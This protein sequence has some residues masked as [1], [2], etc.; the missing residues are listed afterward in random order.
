[1]GENTNIEWAH[2]TCNFWI[3]CT[4][5]SPECERCYA[6]TLAKFHGWAK[7]GAKQPRHKTAPATVNNL[8]KWN[9][10]A[11]AAG[12][13]HR[14]FINSLS[15]TF[16]K[17]VPQSYRDAIFDYA[18]ETPFLD[19]LLLTKRPE[20]FEEMIPLSFWPGEN[21]WGGVTVGVRKS[22]ERIEYLRKSPFRIK[23]LS[24]EPLLEDLGTLNL[25]GIHWVIVGGESGAGARPMHPDWVRS[26]RDQ[27]IA[28]G[29]P[30]LFKQWGEW[31]PSEQYPGYPANM[32]T[33]KNRKS[34]GIDGT[35]P[36]PC[37]EPPPAGLKGLFR[38]GK[39]K[40]GRVL[41]SRTWDEFPS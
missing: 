13:R 21:I 1:M 40:A 23:F 31:C 6:E 2:H 33:L 10:A 14:V 20:N 26:I 7:W 12:E 19:Y 11:E 27:C 39:K 30:F 3:G 29:V 41:D 16:D 37:W 25:E 9:R 5:V 36:G 24:I 32:P 17:E 18:L 34:I 38:V 22:M 28:A 35:S 4:K 15:D 8:R